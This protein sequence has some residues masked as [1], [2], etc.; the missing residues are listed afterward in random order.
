MQEE[1]RFLLSNTPNDICREEQNVA[2]ETNENSDNNITD[3]LFGSMLKSVRNAVFGDKSTLSWFTS[4]LIMV[5]LSYGSAVIIL[6]FTMSQLGPYSWTVYTACVIIILTLCTIL[7]KQSSVYVMCERSDYSMIR[8]PYQKIAEM[9][10]GKKFSIF[11][12]ITL[13]VCLV[14][15]TLAFMLLAATVLNSITNLSTDHITNIRIWVLICFAVSLPFMMHGSYS[16]MSVHALIAII[17]S[18]ISMTCILIITLL[19]QYYYGVHSEDQIHETLNK[20]PTNKHFFLIFG[21]IIFAAA[22]PGIALP[23]IIVLVK[24]PEKFERSIIISHCIIFLIYVIC[25]VVPFTVFDPI[26]EPT[27][28]DTL[29]RHINMLHKPLFVKITLIVCQVCMA[30]HFILVSILSMNPVFLN[31]ENSFDVPVGRF[32]I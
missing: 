4:S 31:L 25:A 10:V 27:I 24:S 11:V 17:T 29:T 14:A 20:L 13:Y 5:S 19:L 8:H 32:I 21:D 6:P 3:S 9:S 16:D 26:A 22:G 2:K 7:L 12:L 18:S 23:N 15:S 30:T 1:Q 28:T